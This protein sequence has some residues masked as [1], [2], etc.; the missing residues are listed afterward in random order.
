MVLPRFVSQAL[1]GQPLTVYGD[2][3]QSRCFTWVGDVVLALIQLAV[4][5]EAVGEIFNI[6]S[7]NEIT[8]RDLAFL[9]KEMTGSNSEVV[10]V[11]YEQAYEQG[12]ED[13]NRRV[14]ALEKIHTLIGYK[15]TIDVRGIIEKVV[16]DLKVRGTSVE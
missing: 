9:V 3:K 2:G 11:P 14:P 1:E 8:I 15:S 7:A 16:E 12:F 10:F 4:N 13:M 6:G 5:S